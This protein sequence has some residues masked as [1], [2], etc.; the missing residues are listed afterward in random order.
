MLR[1]FVEGEKINNSQAKFSSSVGFGVK[2]VALL[3]QDRASRYSRT[4]GCVY[5]TW[6]CL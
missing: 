4:A 3:E 6:S 2:G 1:F 5:V